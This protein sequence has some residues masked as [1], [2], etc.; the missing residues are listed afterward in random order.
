[1]RIICLLLGIVICSISLFLIIIYLNLL[2]IGYT[3]WEFVYFII[4]SGIIWGLLIGI[5]FIYKGMGRI[6]K[7]ELLLRYNFKFSRK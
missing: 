1:M 7:D 5:I 3:F 6:L 2:V 4:R